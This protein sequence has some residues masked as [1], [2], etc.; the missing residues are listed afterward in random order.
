MENNRSSLTALVCLF[1]R[2]YH[3]LYDNPKIFDDFLARNLLTDEEFTQISGYLAGGMKFFNPGQAENFVEPQA[4]LRWV[5]Q[6]QIA[7]LLLT[8]A[9]YC[10]DKLKI[11]L[12]SGIEQYV[13]LGAGMDTFAFRHPE[14]LESVRVFEVD[15]PATQQA[16]I[17]RINTAKWDIPANLNFV[18]V[19]FTEE[20]LAGGLKKAGFDCLKRTY[21]SWLGVTQY[22]SKGNMLQILKETISIIPKGSSIVFDYT[23]D[24]S[25]SSEQS[26]KISAMAQAAG[27]PMKACYGFEELESALKQIGWQVRE[28]LASMDL[29]TKYFLDREDYYHA[30][31]NTN[32]ILA[33]V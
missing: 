19:D 17:N 10:E 25:H 20:G 18:P 29:E 27:E 15:H 8:R 23:N 13:V 28:H 5:V 9:R 24:K 3:S 2:A 22:L 21:L 7:P 26:R 4:A 16:K 11:E 31:E 14:I 32:M 1:G 30:A 6:T 12:A 33:V